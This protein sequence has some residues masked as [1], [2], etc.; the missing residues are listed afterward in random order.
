VEERHAEKKAYKVMTKELDE[1]LG[2][3]EKETPPTPPEEKKEETPE[4]LPQEKKNEDEVQAEAR[5]IILDAAKASQE[6]LRKI[7]TIR[8]KA[9]K[10]ASGD[11]EDEEELPPIDHKDPSV[12]AWD[13]HIGEK[14]SP[15]NKEIEMEKEEVRDLALK[16]FLA[17][18]PAL[19][20]NP[21][22]LKSLMETYNSLAQGRITERNKEKVIQ[23]LEKAYAA[24][25]HEELRSTAH[26]E[27]VEKAKAEE[28]FSGVA[29]SQ[30]S[31]AYPSSKPDKMPPI[32]DEQR[33]II[34][35]MGYK[36]PEEWWKDKQKYQGEV[37]TKEKEEK[38]G[39]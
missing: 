39:D 38:S 33:D 7:R 2:E 24:E 21:E 37:E 6:E 4:E 3:E 11:E 14:V 23:V 35:K 32:D 8:K 20:K 10:A 12:K 15:I 9:T 18:K 19:A 31:T 36:S 5:K 27:K 17:D 25:N 1:I 29:V 34:R 16:D 30:G 28:A 26:K 13:K 22:K